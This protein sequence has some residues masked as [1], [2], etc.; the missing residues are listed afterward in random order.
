MPRKFGWDT[1]SVSGFRLVVSPYLA[2]L[3]LLPR[4]LV[5]LV[6]LVSAANLGSHWH[7][8]SQAH[9][10]AF[11]IR[12]SKQTRNDKSVLGVASKDEQEQHECVWQLR[13][14][15]RTYEE[16]RES[17]FWGGDRPLVL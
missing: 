5:V 13:E 7:V 9:S 1:Q 14:V 11:G 17:G 8:F 10:L 6:F 4:I 15:P 3:V 2:K 16:L 12:L